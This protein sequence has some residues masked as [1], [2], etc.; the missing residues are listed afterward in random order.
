METGTF[1]YRG[2]EYTVEC[3]EYAESPDTWGNDD[4]FLVY[5]HRQFSVERKGFD[6]REIYEHTRDTKRMFYDGHF[7]FKL[8]A[9]IHSGVRLSLSHNGD[10]WDTSMSGFVLVERQKGLAWTRAKAEKVAQEVV[11]EWNEYLGGEVYRWEYMGDA[12]SGY[13]G[14]SGLEQCHAESKCAIDLHIS[15]MRKK[16]IERRKIEIKNRVPL[17]CRKPW[18][19]N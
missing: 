19:I 8:F 14:D 10:R 1:E 9:H 7:V 2:F 17:K 5:D 11:D 6:P 16:H 18:T 13:Y 12:F 15:K 4:A 3:D